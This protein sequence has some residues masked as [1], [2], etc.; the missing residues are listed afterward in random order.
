MKIVDI[1]VNDLKAYKDNPRNNNEQAIN[2]VAE[3]IKNYGFKVPILIDK[4]NEI[5]AGHTRRL[6][7][8]DLGL[9][10]VPAIVADDLTEEQI[11][12]FRITDNR[13]AEFSEWDWEVLK[14]ELE[15]IDEDL[16]TG[17][18]DYFDS[19]TQKEDKQI[20][21]FETFDDEDVETEYRCPK[22]H[23]EWSGKP[24]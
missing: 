13:V 15:Q 20:D 17:F 2:N 23:Y 1:N 18:E 9:E 24:K 11:K 4:N 16:F 8:I 12:A 6:A 22:C 7:A 21:E 14:S 10:T 3:S 19:F 5:I